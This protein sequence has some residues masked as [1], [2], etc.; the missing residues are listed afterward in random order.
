MLAASMVMVTLLAGCGTST[1][2]DAQTPGLFNHYLVYPFSWLIDHFAGWFGGSFGLALIAITVLVRLAL[3]PFMMSQYKRQQNMKH[4]MGRMQPEID[5]IKAKYTKVKDTESLRK[6][7]QETMSV[8]SKHGYNP[9]SLG[10][11]PMLLQIPILS[12]LYYAIRMNPELA[13]HTFLW[14]KLGSTDLIL[15]FVAAAVYLIQAKVAQAG[16]L[17]LNGQ[18]G[19]GWILYLSPVMMGFFSFSMPAA[20][21]LYWCVGGLVMILQTMLSSRIYRIETAQEAAAL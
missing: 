15:P 12:G 4:L 21:P 18:K 20:I 6:Q 10:C 19:M 16:N 1:T 2:I 7:Q 5:A 3:L 13:H 11:L 14:F 17:P 8:Y 9:L